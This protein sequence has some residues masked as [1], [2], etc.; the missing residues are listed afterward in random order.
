MAANGVSTESRVVSGFDRVWL[1][2]DGA[3]SELVVRQGEQESLIVTGRPDILSRVRTDVIDGRLSITLSGSWSEKLG[4]ALATSLTR[5]WIRCDLTVNQLTGLE[6]GGLGRVHAHS[7]SSERL[8]LK[9]HGAGQVKVDSLDAGALQVDL[10]GACQMEV[11]G[12][13]TEQR[14]VVEGMGHYRSPKLESRRATVEIRG[15]GKANVW[16][17][18][19]L[20]VMVRG[21]GSVEYHGAPKVRKNVTPMASV[22]RINGL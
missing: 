3:V 10:N 11:A 13:V 21:M 16:A 4:R 22:V 17:T 6:I 2:V 1:Q 18:D 20:D 9:L 19:K 7:I 12:K 8:A 5:Q 14:V 15:T